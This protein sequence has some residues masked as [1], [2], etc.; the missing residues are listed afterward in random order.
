ML[1]DVRRSLVEEK[2]GPEPTVRCMLVGDG[3]VGKTS[4]IISYIANGYPDEYRQTAFDVFTGSVTV[5]GIP[6]R[7]Q[8][9]DT[10]GQEDYDAFRSLCYEHADVFLLCFSVVC[11]TSFHNVTS[12]WIPEL[13]AQ[14][15]SLPI[16]L[17]GTQADRRHDVNVLIALDQL[18]LSGPV[19]AA[20]GRD[21]A[22][23]IGALD[24]VECSALTQEN[25]K[26]AFDAAIFAAIKHKARRRSGAPGKRGLV[27]RA[28]RI[29][30]GAWKKLFCF[31]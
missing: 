19:G 31:V 30:S 9:M 17:V 7:I 21:L 2:R 11:P 14:R 5:D 13:R 22:D 26:E 23:R 29:S 24:Y 12:K 18:R 25:L 6:V 8:L 10:A 4:M 20:E 16:I 1:P 28:K 27:G 15:P 3:A